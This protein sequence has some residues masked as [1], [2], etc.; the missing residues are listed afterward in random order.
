VVS[1]DWTMAR[2]GRPIADAPETRYGTSRPSTIGFPNGA[3]LALARFPALVQR[4]TWQM[5]TV[6]V[7]SENVMLLLDGQV[8]ERVTNDGWRTGA[9]V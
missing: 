9:W 4:G 3:R 5:L 6:D 1:D 8:V 7:H 2:W